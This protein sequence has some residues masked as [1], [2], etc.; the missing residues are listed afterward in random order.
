VQA[1][2]MAGGLLLLMGWA[3]LGNLMKHIPDSVIKGFTAGIAVIIFTSQI[4]S[5]FGLH[6]DHEPGDV[7]GKWAA[8]FAAS[9]TFQPMAL[10]LGA[11]ALVTIIGVPKIAPK[12]PGFLL[13]VACGAAIVAFAH[14]QVPTIGTRFGGIPSS[15]PLPSLPHFTLERVQELFPSALTI[16]LLAGIESL[17]SAA[18]AD[19]MIGRRH[20]S[21]CELVAQGVANIAS[22]LFGGMPA[23]GAIARTATN[24]RAGGASPVAG[25]MHAVWILMFMLV[26]APLA[27]YVPLSTLAA[28]LFVVAWNMS[29]AKH[30]PHIIQTQPKLDTLVLAV[31]FF[32]TV[33]CDLTIAIGVGTL[34][35]IIVTRTQRQL[36]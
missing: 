26:A 15:L 10:A 27:S 20:R 5:F 19:G 31:T 3:R 33:F 22:A 29:E 7:F 21:N 17:L 28:I 11:L 24:V 34:L 4:G 8:Y 23:T 9:A 6:L 13:A 32:L 36:V 12:V 14:W 18:V 1:T 16:A 35:G 30:L 25:M 2:L